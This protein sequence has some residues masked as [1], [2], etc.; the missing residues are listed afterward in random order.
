[1]KPLQSYSQDDQLKIIKR[2]VVEIYSEHELLQRLK[3]GR[4]L[5]VKL[6]LDP[7]TKDIHLGHT[8][9][10]QKL[11]QFQDLGHQAVIIIGDFTA[12]IG[13]PS[14]RDK[15]RPQLSRNE[16]EQNAQTYLGQ[17][18]KVLELKRL[19]IVYNSTWLNKLTMENIVKLAAQVTVARFI[20]RDDF[21]LR[22]KKQIPISLHEFLYPLLQGQDSVAVQADV[23]LGGTDQTFNLLV[24][25]DLQK[26]VNMP[27]Q[28]V[29]TM[30]LLI[31]L[32]G[33][34]KMSKSLDNHIAI[35]EPPFEMYSKIMSLPDNLMKNYF[36]LLT[37]LS[38]KEINDALSEH[39]KEAKIKLAKE[40]IT[41]YYDK[42]EA[43]NC[44]AKFEAV[45]SRKEV[46]EDSIKLKIES[47]I[48]NKE[49]KVYLPKL[50]N[51]CGATKSNSE[52]RR[53]ITQGGVTIDGVKLTD[54]DS[55]IT[56]KTG[57]I[58]KIGKKNRF[59]RIE[60]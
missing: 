49:G 1:M 51:F 29:L 5:R 59:Y 30:P 34:K 3:Q 7:T 40:I 23:E 14:G 32:D 54:S 8:V 44:A 57:Q 35:T 53:L 36:T 50:L 13:D 20:E 2:G 17:V 58:L 56:V 19:E 16:I 4:P 46:P 24:G 47:S 52:A 55:E 22:L 21:N 26:S 41:K 25:R 12:S 27:P 45:F 28:I 31:G 43:D 11:R 42:I 33:S 6:G 48:L 10:L 18:G 38:E 60:I 9:V 39:P 37:L 15:T